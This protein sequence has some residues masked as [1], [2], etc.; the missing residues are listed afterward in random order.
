MLWSMQMAL[1]L[2]QTAVVG[3]KPIKPCWWIQTQR[4]QPFDTPKRELQICKLPS[5]AEN[6]ALI[7]KFLPGDDIAQL[8]NIHLGAGGWGSVVLC[9]LAHVKPLSSTAQNKGKQTKLIH[10]SGPL[11]ID[12]LTSAFDSSHPTQ[13]SASEQFVAC[14]TALINFTICD[15][16]ISEYLVFSN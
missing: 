3:R 15:M 16:T 1:P 7:I 13:V 2:S 9:C 10:L 5:I 11:F 4:L 6:V 12:I 14:Q 8:P